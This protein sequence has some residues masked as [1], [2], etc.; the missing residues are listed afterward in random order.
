MA[1]EMTIRESWT[2]LE[3]QMSIM[4]RLIDGEFHD[5][6]EAVVDEVKGSMLEF[7]DKM[8]QVAS[9]DLEECLS[10][11]IPFQNDEE[12]MGIRLEPADVEEEEEEEYDAASDYRDEAGDD[13]DEDSGTD[14]ESD[15]ESSVSG[16]HPTS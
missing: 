15:G 4:F 6:C 10:V 11:P 9:E 2:K 1:E 5:A 14:D 16:G 3:A 13:V 7:S 8:G 12:E